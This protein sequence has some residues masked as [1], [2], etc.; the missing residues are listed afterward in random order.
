MAPVMFF[1]ARYSQINPQIQWMCVCACLGIFVCKTRAKHYIM[2]PSI[3]VDDLSALCSCSWE[4]IK[5]WDGFRA[6]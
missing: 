1:L 3:K 5:L 2:N 4:Q 6:S